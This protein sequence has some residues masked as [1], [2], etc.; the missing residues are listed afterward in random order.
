MDGAFAGFRPR[1]FAWFA[2]LEQDNT[3]EY[4]AATRPVYD[5]RRASANA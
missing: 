3:R 1:V 5:G 2:G 4:F